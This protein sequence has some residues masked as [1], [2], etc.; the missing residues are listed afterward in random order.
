MQKKNINIT[1]TN[2][3]ICITIKP[4]EMPRTNYETAK[5]KKNCAILNRKKTSWQKR[6]S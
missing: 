6:K 5:R 1:V 4:I 2:H 3:N